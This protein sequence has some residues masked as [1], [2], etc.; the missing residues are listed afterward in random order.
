MLQILGTRLRGRS[1]RETYA[2][3]TR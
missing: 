2:R 3:K 1:Y